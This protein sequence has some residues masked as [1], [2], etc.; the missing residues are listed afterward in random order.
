FRQFASHIKS[1]TYMVNRIFFIILISLISNL[2]FGQQVNISDSTS[3]WRLGFNLGGAW[4][5]SDIKADAGSGVGLTLER[6]FTRNSRHAVGFSLRGRYLHAQTKGE[7]WKKSTGIFNN[8]ALNGTYDSKLDYT[9]RGF[10]YHNY[11]TKINEFTLE[12]M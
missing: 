4:Q 11:E 9:S 12:G 7:D 5:Q 10:I 2:G 6:S 3:R 1:R 8:P